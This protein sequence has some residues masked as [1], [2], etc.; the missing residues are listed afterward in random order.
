MMF[1]KLHPPNHDWKQKRFRL[2]FPAEMHL[3]SKKTQLHTHSLPA[4]CLFL[5]L[6][7]CGLQVNSTLPSTTITSL[8]VFSIVCIVLF[9][10][11]WWTTDI[12]SFID[13]IKGNFFWKERRENS[14]QEHDKMLVRVL[15][16]RIFLTVSRG[17]DVESGTQP[18]CSHSMINP[19]C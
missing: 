12:F 4:T 7:P 15:S 14:D 11:S 18:S 1:H 16:L 19:I 13:F 2:Q 5:S 6:K 3:G 8:C 17:L 10:I 9:Y